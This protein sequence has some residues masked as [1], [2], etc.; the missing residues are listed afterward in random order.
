MKTTTRTGCQNCFLIF[1]LLAF[2]FLTS[3]AARL[4]KDYWRQMLPKKFPSLTSAPSR[5][6]NSASVS[7][8]SPFTETQRFSPSSGGKV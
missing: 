7:S 2:I 8:V 5:G 3:D 1:F 6:T 4:P